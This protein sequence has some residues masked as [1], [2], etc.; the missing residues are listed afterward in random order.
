MVLEGATGC[1]LSTDVACTQLPAREAR[2]AEALPTERGGKIKGCVQRGGGARKTCAAIERARKGR[3]SFLTLKRKRVCHP[4]SRRVG[5]G[6]GQ[7]LGHYYEQWPL[8]D[9]CRAREAERWRENPSQGMIPLS[10]LNLKM[11]FLRSGCETSPLGSCNGTFGPAGG[12]V[13]GGC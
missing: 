12:A 9:T 4:R 8:G 5:E 10:C 7:A 2:E 13:P 1:Q 6:G 11:V 3:T